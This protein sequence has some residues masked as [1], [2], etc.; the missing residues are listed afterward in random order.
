MERIAVSASYEAIQ[1]G[2]SPRLAPLVA[3]A[4]AFTWI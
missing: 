4:Q 3:L 1:H 2:N